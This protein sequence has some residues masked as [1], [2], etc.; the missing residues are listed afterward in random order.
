MMC[1]SKRF[2]L[3]VVGVALVLLI[4]ASSVMGQAFRP[5]LEVVKETG[6]L[7]VGCREA[8]PP[9][10]YV[11]EKGNMVGFSQDMAFLLAKKMEERVGREVTVKQVPFAGQAGFL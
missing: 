7:K 1:V 10:A 3:L 4:A 8:A 9:F 2:V 6:V 11:D 5:V